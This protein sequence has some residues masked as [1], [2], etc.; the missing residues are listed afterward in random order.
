MAVKLHIKLKPGMKLLAVI[1]L[2]GSLGDML[3]EPDA[4]PEVFRWTDSGGS[5]VTARFL[6][7]R[8]LEHSIQRVESDETSS[9]VGHDT[10]VSP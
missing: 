7:G 6:D 2:T 1:G 10:T 8:L 4:Q 5:S 3:S 9:D